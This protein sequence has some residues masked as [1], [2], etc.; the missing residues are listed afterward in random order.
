MPLNFRKSLSFCLILSLFGVMEYFSSCLDMANECQEGQAEVTYNPL[1]SFS[2]T[3]TVPARKQ[4]P[5]SQPECLISSAEMWNERWYSKCVFKDTKDAVLRTRLVNPTASY[6]AVIEACPDTCHQGKTCLRNHGSHLSD[7]IFRKR[8]AFYELKVN[9]RLDY[10]VGLLEAHNNLTG[11]FAEYEARTVNTKEGDSRMGHYNW[12]HMVPD[13]K[14]G[15]IEVCPEKFASVYGMSMGMLKRAK[16][17]MYDKTKSPKSA[18]ETGFNNRSKECDQL[19]KDNCG[20]S[21]EVSFLVNWLINWAKEG[22]AEIQPHGDSINQQSEE[23]TVYRLHFRSWKLIYAC[24]MVVGEETVNKVDI[25]KFKEVFRTHPKLRNIH[26]SRQKANF[27]ICSIC[28]NNRQKFLNTSRHDIAAR[29]KLA[30]EWIRHL[31]YITAMRDVYNANIVQAVMNQRDYLF[32]ECDGWTKT[33]SVVSADLY[34]I[35]YLNRILRRDELCCLSVVSSRMKAS[36]KRNCSLQN[37]GPL[38]DV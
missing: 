37:K 38:L 25:K 5:T 23:D 34:G 9:Q 1:S 22:F 3:N 19:Y 6:M 33:A 14:G 24:Y 36:K 7:M 28:E 11:C 29:D 27:A 30:T 35:L 18:P 31:E 2:P 12:K 4:F 21:D 17:R 8:I 13:E 10:V 32:M 26:R 16:K 20:D 15:F